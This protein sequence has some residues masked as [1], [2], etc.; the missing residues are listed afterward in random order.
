M[1]LFPHL[2]LHIPPFD[3][4]AITNI[5]YVPSLVGNQGDYASKGCGDDDKAG[6]E[7]MTVLLRSNSPGECILPGEYAKISS[8]ESDVSSSSVTW[9]PG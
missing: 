7:V 6:I 9:L 2:L 5:L 3:C 1:P 4:R 8:S